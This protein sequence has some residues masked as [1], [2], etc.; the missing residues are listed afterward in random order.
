MCSGKADYDQS[1]HSGM[2]ILLKIMQIETNKHL[3]AGEPPYAGL[4][5]WLEDTRIH[6]E[7]TW[8]TSSLIHR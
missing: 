2:K 7:T 8:Q 3:R 6:S 4:Q 5:M 1:P